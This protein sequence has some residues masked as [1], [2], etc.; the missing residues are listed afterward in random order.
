MVLMHACNEPSVE[1]LDQERADSLAVDEVLLQSTPQRNESLR[2]TVETKRVERHDIEAQRVKTKRALDVP[3]ATKAMQR[4]V[5]LADAWHW[6]A[7]RR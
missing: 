7:G 5:R 4:C 2:E 6:P 1:L 3:I